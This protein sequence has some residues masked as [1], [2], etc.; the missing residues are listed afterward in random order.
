MSLQE[1]EALLGPPDRATTCG[2]QRWLFWYRI[3]KPYG[4]AHAYFYPPGRPGYKVVV[5]Q[6]EGVIEKADT[7][8]RY[9]GVMMM[10][11]CPDGNDDR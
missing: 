6:P 10:N 4:P 2:T 11:P 5:D 8:D 1:V 7:T 9:S 3:E